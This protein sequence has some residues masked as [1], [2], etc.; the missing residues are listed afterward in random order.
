MAIGYRSD[1]DQ[2]IEAAFRVGS[3][4]YP[5]CF[6]SETIALTE[7]PDSR[8]AATLLPSMHVGRD[9]VEDEPVTPKLLEAT[10]EIQDILCCWHSQFEKVDVR[11]IPAEQRASPSEGR[12]GCFFTGG[13][14]HIWIS[15]S[16]HAG[17]F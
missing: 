16:V 5:I 10:D 17:Q 11:A 8:I 7:S 12:V 9:V 1:L 6:R 3:K 2:Q 4:E 14:D 15:C 13:V